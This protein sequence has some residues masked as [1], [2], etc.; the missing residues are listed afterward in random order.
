MKKHTFFIVVILLFN[1]NY[2]YSYDDQ[3]SHRLISVEAARTAQAQYNLEQYIIDNFNLKDGFDTKLK[4]HI[5]EKTLSILGWLQ[6]GAE[7]EDYPQCRA[8]NHFHNPLKSWGEAGMSDQPSWLDIVCGVWKPW[9]S[10][11]TW[12]TGYKSPSGTKATFNPP[13]G[14]FVFNWDKAR[15]HY[16][17]ALTAAGQTERETDF[18]LTFET[19]GHIMHLLG[20]VSV[21]SHVR[22]DFRSHLI[23]DG[24]L[25]T[26]VYQPYERYVKKNA[27]LIRNVT[28]TPEDFPSAERLTAFWDGDIY[29]NLVSEPSI[30]NAL[31]LAEST[32]SSYFSYL[33]IPNNNPTLEHTFPYPAINNQE[34]D[35]CEDNAPG[36]SQ[37]KVKYVSRKDKGG[38]DHFATVSSLNP[39]YYI[40][41]YTYLNNNIS[42]IK[43]WLDASVH[44]TYAN[45]LLPRAIGYS[46]GLLN[47]FFRGEMEVV[48][49]A[50]VKPVATLS[51]GEISSI[52]LVIK[53]MT[54]GEAMQGGE[55]VV[56]YEY[57]PD[58]ETVEYGT[59]SPI[60]IDVINSDA[61]SEELT[62]TFDADNRIPLDSD[63]TTFRVVYKGKLGNEEGAVAVSRPFTP[64]KYSIP[65]Y[66]N[67]SGG[68]LVVNIGGQTYS[69][70]I[71]GYLNGGF[72]RVRFAE[73]NPYI[74]GVLVKEGG[75]DPDFVVHKFAVSGGGIVYQGVGKRLPIKVE[76][77]PTFGASYINYEDFYSERVNDTPVDDATET[78]SWGKGTATAVLDE[79][80]KEVIRKT[81]TDLY[82]SNTGGTVKIIGKYEIDAF[83]TQKT[84]SYEYGYVYPNSK[85]GIQNGV[86]ITADII[87]K[88]V[89]EGNKIM[90]YHYYDDVLHHNYPVE[91]TSCTFEISRPDAESKIEI[92]V[93]SND[94]L[95]TVVKY[96]EI[97]KIVDDLDFWYVSN[98]CYYT[99]EYDP[100]TCSRWIEYYAENLCAGIPY[101]GIPDYYPNSISWAEITVG[102]VA[103]SADKYVYS[104][105]Y[106]WKTVLAGNVLT[107]YYWGAN[108]L[109]RE[110]GNYSVALL[111]ITIDI[112]HLDYEVSPNTNPNVPACQSLLVS[113]NDEVILF[114]PYSSIYDNPVVLAFPEYKGCSVY[115]YRSNGQVNP[116]ME[117]AVPYKGSAYS[118]VTFKRLQ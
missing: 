99:G 94:Q 117:M 73:G 83:W 55:L 31:G 92:G 44:E 102:P 115:N 85:I 13:S 76:R 40:D 70:P 7:K 100:N 26:W 47:Y 5:E 57:R 48:T 101:E 11:V 19:L 110:A 109:I 56:T 60:A 116:L 36:S 53:N 45:E 112:Y 22:N 33:T 84:T 107:N 42:T 51:N 80:S 43:L 105:N 86:E 50:S 20:D 72:R 108:S 14:F 97:L 95:E 93:F 34:Y 79:N 98:K 2:A 6:D 106:G 69:A 27:A 113:S 118:D 52:R 68:N 82:I 24:L 71:S 104:E 12:A 1:F 96:D 66:V 59:S 18:A 28:L 81:A 25:F 9:Y 88:Y 37:I 74:I 23:S 103:L 39:L 49:D 54:P 77:P 111:D 3:T 38:C 90:I 32:N 91:F 4:N 89:L 46:A 114:S 62:F 17:K 15:A 30:S 87:T 64:V 65:A 16:H 63:Q 29:M 10:N 21:P 61:T 41:D 8:S 58:A 78:Q 75:E 35:I 67:Y